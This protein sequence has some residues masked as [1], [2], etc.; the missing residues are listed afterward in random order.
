VH[1]KLSLFGNALK[2]IPSLGGRAEASKRSATLRFC[3]ET[4][5]EESATLR[6]CAKTFGKKAQRCAFVRKHSGK[7]AQRRAFVRR[8]SGRKR[9]AA[10]LCGD[11]REESATLRFRAEAFEKIVAGSFR[12]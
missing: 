3:A 12:I 2:V 5:G 9:N 8:R 10:L 1:S 7:K 11:V 6:F 4:F